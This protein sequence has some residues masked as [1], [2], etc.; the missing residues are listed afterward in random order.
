MSH[1]VRLNSPRMTLMRQISADFSLKKD[2]VLLKNP[3]KSVASGLSAA[4]S[5]SQ[6]DDSEL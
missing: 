6:R 3:R 5:N 4:S 2:G 1:R